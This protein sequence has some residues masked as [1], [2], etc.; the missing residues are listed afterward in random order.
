MIYANRITKS[1]YLFDKDGEWVDEGVYSDVLGLDKTYNEARWY[2]EFN[3]QSF[4]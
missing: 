1:M 4:M 2:D 3:V